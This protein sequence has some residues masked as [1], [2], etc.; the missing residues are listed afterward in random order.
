M[1]KKM[2]SPMTQSNATCSLKGLQLDILPPIAHPLC[3]PSFWF[4]TKCLLLRTESNFLQF[5]HWF[6]LQ[7]PNHPHFPNGEQLTSCNLISACLFLGFICS[8]YSSSEGGHQYTKPLPSRLYLYPA[9]PQQHRAD[10]N[11]S[12]AQPPAI[13]CVDNVFVAC[14]QFPA[15]SQFN[16]QS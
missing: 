7:S 13:C 1:L 8:S 12:C 6:Q 16:L 9:R 5:A 4:F 10:A 2:V 11:P 15:F 14:A 3:F